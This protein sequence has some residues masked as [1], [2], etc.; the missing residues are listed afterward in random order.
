MLK[1]LHWLSV[2]VRKKSV[3]INLAHPALLYYPSVL[4]SELVSLSP[5][6]PPSLSLSLPSPSPLPTFLAQYYPLTSCL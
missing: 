3:F 4:S 5:F 2:M 1:T 6:L